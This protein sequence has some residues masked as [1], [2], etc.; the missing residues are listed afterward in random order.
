MNWHSLTNKHYFTDPE[1]HVSATAIVDSLEYDRLYEN[2]NN[3]DHKQWQEFDE[4]YK[5]GFEFLE[6]LE[7]VDLA[8]PVIALWFFKERSDRQSQFYVNIG[9][10]RIDYFPNAILL[11]KSK[12]VKIEKGKKIYIRSPLLQLDMSEKQYEEICQ[13]IRTN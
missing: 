3:L 12:N 10:K 13:R 4:K 2:Q 1:E 7:D 6:N 11:T 8:R 9:G 5:T